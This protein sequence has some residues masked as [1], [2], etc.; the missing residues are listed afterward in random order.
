MYEILFR[1]L[2]DKPRAEP[3]FISN[4]QVVMENSKDS[5]KR[6]TTIEAVEQMASDEHDKTKT[7]I[8]GGRSI[9][10]IDVD[11]D[12]EYIHSDDEGMIEEIVTT[13]EQDK[14]LECKIKKKI[15]TKKTIAQ[16][17]TTNSTITKVVKT[18][19]TEITRTITI[20]DHHDLERAKRELGIDDVNRL[21]PSSTWLEQQSRSTTSQTKEKRYEPINEIVTSKDFPHD[22]PIKKSVQ[23]NDEKTILAES[24]SVGRGPVTETIVSTPSNIETKSIE[25]KKKKKK[26]KFCSCTRSSAEDEQEPSQPQP[27]PKAIIDP[28]QETSIQSQKLISDDLKQLITEKKTLLIEYLH[29]KIFL[30]ANLFSSNDQNTQAK[31]ISSRILDLLSS[32]RYSSWS[33]LSE[34]LTQE[35]INDSVADQCLKPMINT[36]E[37]LFTTKQANLL[38]TFSTIHNENDIENIHENNDYLNIAQTH[39]HQSIDETSDD[40]PDV[41]QSIEK[42]EKGKENIRLL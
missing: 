4:E 10:R 12:E 18:E 5:K 22:S 42:E 17:P 1:I 35:Y 40:K 6:K 34:Q 8:L 32:D 38:N 30:P 26:L 27:Q 24:T 29:S 14:D 31:Q 23:A 16:H 11:N 33:Q 19:V 15:E 25:I 9:H 39:I 13:V 36:Y 2:V 41:I 21:L 28:K 7:R 20:N 37:K 3:T